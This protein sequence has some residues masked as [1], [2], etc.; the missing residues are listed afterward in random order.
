MSWAPHPLDWHKYTSAG[1]CQLHLRP[2]IA[3][4]RAEGTGDMTT[5][6]RERTML[7]SQ[8][9]TTKQHKEIKHNWERYKHC[10][11]HSIE[12]RTSHCYAPSKDKMLF[13]Q[14]WWDTS[15]SQ[16]LKLMTDS[17]TES[18]HHTAAPWEWWQET[19]TLKLHACSSTTTA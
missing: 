19:S 1:R 18:W 6:M 15:R 12:H 13:S 10:L 2:G 17:P 4:V 16:H 5:I 8:H 9:R 7:T 14:H 11:I 3:C